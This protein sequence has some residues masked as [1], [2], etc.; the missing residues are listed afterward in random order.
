MFRPRPARQSPPPPGVRRELAR[1][2]R[3]MDGGQFAEAASVFEQLFDMARRRGML[4]RA[5]DLALQ[6]ARALVSLLAPS[7]FFLLP[8]KL[9]LT[10]A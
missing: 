7:F 4:V 10:L 9:P 2:N 1:V 3:L 6:A 8:V 5:G